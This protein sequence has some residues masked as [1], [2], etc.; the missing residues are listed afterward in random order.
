VPPKVQLFL[1]LLSHNK[2]ATVDNVNKKG[3]Q[4]PEQCMFCAEKE[5]INH[6]FFECSIARV[7]WSYANECLDMN[8][9]VD[10]ISV[11]SK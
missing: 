1:W 5:S 9:G 7:I 2:L 8:L 11:A 6:L 4:K 3:M 10:Y